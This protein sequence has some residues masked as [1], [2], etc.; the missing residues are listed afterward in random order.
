MK[1]SD[2]TDDCIIRL[3]GKISKIIPVLEL[4]LD[5]LTKE[6]EALST[7]DTLDL[8]EQVRYEPTKGKM[9][10][11]P[12]VEITDSGVGTFSEEKKKLVSEYNEQ[13]KMYKELNQKIFDCKH[14][15]ALFESQGRIVKTPRDNPCLFAEQPIS[16]KMVDEITN[17]L[18][19]LPPSAHQPSPFDNDFFNDGFSNVS[20]PN[21]WGKLWLNPDIPTDD[22]AA[23][24]DAAD[25]ADFP[26]SVRA[27]FKFE[28][29][30]QNVWF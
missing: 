25:L 18:A 17:K 8:S 24:D 13:F 28:D 30:K 27:L 14:Q 19:E 22:E 10:P 21:Q 7:S 6:E 16:Q 20:T 4:E 5:V 15:I 29:K 26:P 11:L 12:Y 1:A 23:E 9:F 2:L 3:I